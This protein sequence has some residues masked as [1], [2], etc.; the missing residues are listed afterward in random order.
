[1]LALAVLTA[2]LYKLP[3]KKNCIK[4]HSKCLP[5]IPSIPFR[6]TLTC[7]NII[8]TLTGGGGSFTDTKL[9]TLAFTPFIQSYPELHSAW[10]EATL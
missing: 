7:A 6:G 1:M 10:L 2:P 3:I 5:Y 4:T 8:I 9:I